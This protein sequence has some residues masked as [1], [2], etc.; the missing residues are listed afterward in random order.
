MFLESLLTAAKRRGWTPFVPRDGS[1]PLIGD[2]SH[3]MAFL[4]HSG[5]I[6]SRPTSVAKRWGDG[7]SWS[8]EL[9]S[10]R[11]G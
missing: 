11:R 9:A 2:I 6:L 1:K 8:L 4:T 10:K 3:G 7:G 5:S